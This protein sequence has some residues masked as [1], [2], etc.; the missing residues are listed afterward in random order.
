[1]KT[2]GNDTQ[3]RNAMIRVSA[4][5]TVTK[6][7]PKLGLKAGDVYV[8]SFSGIIDTLI[9]WAKTKKLEYFAIEH[10]SDQ[11]NIHYHIVIIFDE[12]SQAKF[13]QVKDHFPFG[14]INRCEHG[15]SSCVKYLIHKMNPEKFQY[16][17]DLIKTNSESSLLKY[18]SLSG[19]SE[20]K[21]L[22]KLC[23]MIIDGD[24]KEY[25]IEKISSDIFTKHRR[26]IDNAFEY[27]RRLLLMDTN[28][29]VTV[30]YIQGASAAGKTTFCKAYAKTHNLSIK[31]SS[32]GRHPLEGYG[33]EDVLVLDDVKIDEIPITEMLNTIDP[34]NNY[35]ISVRYKRIL[36]TGKIIFICSNKDIFD[37][38]KW[39]DDRVLDAFYR[40]I[41]YVFDFYD[42]DQN[43]ISHYSVNYIHVKSKELAEAERKSI[44]D[45]IKREKP[46]LDN[47]EYTKLVNQK[48]ER[49]R[50]C[51]IEDR[52]FD[53][54]QYI[55]T[56]KS[57]DDAFLKTLDVV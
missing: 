13:S 3:M 44:L 10:Y 29:D 1:M 51:K 24:I 33:N 49:A 52:S 15:V 20:R 16:E 41:K 56:K 35:E 46:Y 11:N 18:L 39:E 47:Y 4:K 27:R 14:V 19:Y 57:D 8:V 36:F 28:R 43:N 37:W 5:N 25:Q 21:L 17:P 53:L 9:E 40:R 26:R 30:I 55:D 23:K 34:N 12:N 50:L 38:Y 31:L 48:F 54:N 45:E 2:I 42:K 32:S 22:E 6:D 7:Y